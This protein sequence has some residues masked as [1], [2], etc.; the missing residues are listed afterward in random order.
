MVC[1]VM[2]AMGNLDPGKQHTC[3]QQKVLSFVGNRVYYVSYGIT[4]AAYLLDEGGR[5]TVAS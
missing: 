1:T 4:T 2:R 5:A 3:P